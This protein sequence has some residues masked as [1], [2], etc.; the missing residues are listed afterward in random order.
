MA[1]GLVAGL[2]GVEK[3]QA[4]MSQS[5]TCPG[6]GLL[7]GCS[8]QCLSSSGPA[9]RLITQVHAQADHA[10]VLWAPQ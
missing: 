4:P 1:N 2:L 7:K 3:L 9:H 8:G 10:P 5:L 6:P